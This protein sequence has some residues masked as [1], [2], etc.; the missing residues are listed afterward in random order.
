M[1][2]LRRVLLAREDMSCGTTI[3][4]AII[5]VLCLNFLIV[6]TKLPLMKMIETGESFA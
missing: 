3:R 4:Y 5:S 2:L 1:K 6:K